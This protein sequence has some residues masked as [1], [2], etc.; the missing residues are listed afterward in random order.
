MLEYKTQLETLVSQQVHPS[1]QDQEFIAVGGVSAIT[2]VVN[3]PTTNN[4]SN[5]QF[6]LFPSSTDTICD[7]CFILKA[8]VSALITST[9]TGVAADKNAFLPRS[10]PITSCIQRLILELN[11]V[12]FSF[13]SQE[14]KGIVENIGY[15]SQWKDEH[16]RTPVYPEIVGT[17]AELALKTNYAVFGD[18][19]KMSGEQTPHYSYR[20]SSTLVD[21][22]T[23]VT[24]TF[25]EPLFIPTLTELC[26]GREA[27]HGL[28]SIKVQIQWSNLDKGESM[29]YANAAGFATHSIEFTETAVTLS[30]STPASAAP[31][32]SLINRYI[33]A[34]D[35][36]P[37]NYVKQYQK[38]VKYESPAITVNSGSS[39]SFNIAI[40]ASTTP[41]HMI[42]YVAQ[43]KSPDNLKLDLTTALLTSINIRAGTN[44]GR[45]NN[46][47]SHGMFDIS[48]KNGLDYNYK[49]WIASKSIF[50]VDVGADMPNQFV[51]S[52][53]AWNLSV[54]CT[55]LSSDSAM[56]KMY[57]YLLNPSQIMFQD[58]NV[59]ISEGFDSFKVQEAVS[60]VMPEANMEESV[61][62]GGSFKS[63]FSKKGFKKLGRTIFKALPI[64]NALISTGAKAMPNNVYAQGALANFQKVQNV[65]N[66]IDNVTG[67][68]ISGNKKGGSMM[69]GSK[70]AG[71]YNQR[72]LM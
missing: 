25:Y 53:Q 35:P 1:E 60:N 31:I 50:L 69:A 11:N 40:N 24:Y 12:Q 23:N 29:F 56:Y 41:S 45:F 55:A 71:N 42:I 30:G 36:V 4:R 20:T 18:D 22:V 34:S 3:T 15:N 58:Q 66:Q 10:F 57:V 17:V 28:T 70:M 51:G 5:L 65:A 68:S 13:D 54:N 44:D 2:E 6:N 21:K 16:I 26:I 72:Q 39:Q 62:T 9:V 33:Q 43:G 14:L 8:E 59:S 37:R 63:F 48:K 49:T 47:D 46:L 32:Y 27:M 64:V 61:P 19:T 52:N 7:M 67:N 38:Y